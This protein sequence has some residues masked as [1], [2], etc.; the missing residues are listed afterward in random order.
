MRK[1]MSITLV[2][3]LALS[4]SAVARPADQ[5]RTLDKLSQ[6]DASGVAKD[7][8]G[9][10]NPG[11]FGA[12]VAGTVFF[13]GTVWAADS[14]RWEALQNQTWT[15]NTGVGSSMVGHGPAY[16]NP[17]KDP[18]LHAQMNGWVGIDNSYSEIPYFRRV[19]SA[20][21]NWGVGGHPCTGSLGGL[22]GTFSFWCGAFPA[23]ANARC[24][25]NG[26]GYGNN[27]NVCMEHTFLYGG[28]NVT[29]AFIY[30]NDTEDGY[31]YTHVYVDTTGL[32]D[33][34]EVV[35]YTARTTTTQSES[36]T[37]VPGV[38]LPKSGLPKNIKIKFC[39][40]SDTGW[41]D[42]DGLN[43][44]VCGA[45]AVD[46]I[47]ITGGITHSTNFE[48]GADGWAL[49]PAAKGRGEEWSNLYAIA[50]L[51]PTGVP[52]T[53]A[54][55]DT[56]LCFKNGSNSH[57]KYTDNTA[58]SPWIDLKA[59]GLVGA[60]GKIVKTNIFANLPLANYLF[61]QFNVQWYPEK[62]IQTGKLIT[63]TFTSNGF[64]Y[65]FGGVA[66]CTPAP[67]GSTLGT[68]IDFSGFVPAGAE[69]MRIALGVYSFCQFPQYAARCTGAPNSSPWFDYAALGVYGTPG[70][71][72]IFADGIDRGQDNFPQNGGLQYNAP[73]RIDS[74]N[75]QGASYPDVG[76]TM[77][78][79]MIVTGGVG[80]AAVYV[81]FKVDA[82]PGVN[83]ANF[84]AWYG[85]HAASGIDG[86]F[87]VA[88]MDTAEF[89]LSGAL[90]GN[91]MTCYHEQDPNFAAHGANDQTKDGTDL[92]PLGGT[93]RLSHDIFPD[94]LFPAG[95][96]IDYFFSAND[97]GT[98]LVYYVDP[99]GAPGSAAPYE[100]E[101]L[102]SSFDNLN[103]FNCTLYVDHFNRG[104]QVYIE[105]GL[106]AVLPGGSANH[107]NT[108]W[109]RDDI[110]AESS[111]QG[112]LGRP[113]QSD[114]GAT[115]VQLFGYKNILIDTGN[116]QG[117]NISKEDG[118]QLKPWLTVTDIDN[119]NLWLSGD[120]I[121]FAGITEGDAAPSARSLLLDL[122][123]VE[124]DVDCAT[125]TY[126]NAACPAGGSPQ[127]LTACVNLDPV[128]GAS[129][130]GNPV[131]AINHVGQGNG[132][133]NLRSFD[134]LSLLAPNFG[135]SKGDERYSSAVKNA[136]YASVSQDAAVGGTPG[137]HY[138]IVTDGV[139][140][141]YRR[142]NNA[143]CLFT[144]AAGAVTERIRE[145]LT[146]FSAA[147]EVG[148]LDF[149][150][151]VGVPIEDRQIRT[152]TTLA[153]FAPNPLMSGAAG[154]IQFTMKA[155]GRA[156][157]EV[158]DIEGR[159][160]K[161]VYSG[162]AKEGINDAYWNGTDQSGRQVASG[163]FFYRLRTSLG[164]DL[165]KKMVVVSNGGK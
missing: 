35:R 30:R 70:A 72:F 89:G 116:L 80:N 100:V 4:T 21:A 24:Y 124:Y 43:P 152:R 7:F 82:G 127:D 105:A 108:R 86:T 121:V 141:H 55:N 106:A 138:R 76:T 1:A 16:V 64:V 49:A 78:D 115:V 15:F 126:R 6:L 27:W 65:Y 87:K 45:F 102:P 131:R 158:F 142:D 96:H 137:L 69:Q 144:S 53:C 139:S 112:S 18:S 71:P 67:V 156:T 103:Q 61:T 125:G 110:N 145:V 109:D 97:V 81:H 57:N 37:L 123:G 134:V 118:D 120:G 77:G 85:S 164:D 17:Y 153:D 42:E 60:P 32:G 74:N 44:T 155:E 135:T 13:G 10:G 39:V 114:Y 33:L 63:S 98:P 84:N 162:L 8:V 91:W 19:G 148:C 111:Q 143:S 14:A 154:H 54:L 157:I 90:S 47:A 29:L 73:G 151:G 23:E 79:T 159:L 31:D 62:C 26:Q 99:P 122:A 104:A 94:N 149:A 56:V 93:W 132:C 22:G 48:G 11:V 50:D 38:E 5:S 41:S 95:T 12:A 128:I 2:L 140:V 150:G 161:S 25:A 40:T 3:V 83:V 66:Q 9:T 51:G 58:A 119:R 59:A 88:R 165:S 68:Q 163:V 136:D 147:A 133:P 160:V 101:I 113:L 46:N 52:C 117:F 20:D 92:T 129:V 34:V 75:I 28:S 36:K 146:Y 107:E 130:A